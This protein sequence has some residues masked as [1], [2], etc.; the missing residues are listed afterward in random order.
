MLVS[1][2]ALL[3]SKLFTDPAFGRTMMLPPRKWLSDNGTLGKTEQQTADKYSSN[4]LLY[5]TLFSLSLM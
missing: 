4:C 1:V 5:I 2:A 3:T